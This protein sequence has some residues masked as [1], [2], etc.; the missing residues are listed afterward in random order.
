MRR[1]TALTAIILMLALT[2]LN[3]ACLFRGDD[4]S[5]EAK[6]IIDRIHASAESAGITIEESDVFVPVI[7]LQDNIDVDISISE[8]DDGV[9][10]IYALDPENNIINEYELELANIVKFDTA[11]KEEIENDFPDHWIRYNENGIDLYYAGGYSE[12]ESGLAFVIVYF[13][14][15]KTVFLVGGYMPDQTELSDPLIE[16]I[17]EDFQCMTVEE[18][19]ARYAVSS[20]YRKYCIG[21]GE[22]S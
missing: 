14:D 13:I 2:G 8:D 10:V 19:K 11:E 3:T 4:L 17:Y 5:E 22:T 18:L 1:I 20:F 21:I 12:T 9:Q 7:F 15:D 16:D 6:D